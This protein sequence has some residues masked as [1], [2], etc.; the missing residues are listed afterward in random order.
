MRGPGY[1]GICSIPHENLK[2]KTALKYL[3]K[4][5][6]ISVTFLETFAKGSATTF[7]TGIVVCYPSS[8]NFLNYGL[9]TLADA[10]LLVHDGMFN[11]QVEICLMSLQGEDIAQPTLLKV[12]S[13]LLS[14]PL[15]L[16]LNPGSNRKC[17]S[18]AF[19]Y[20][21]AT[22]ESMRGISLL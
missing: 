2:K 12:S 14:D 1:I 8:D 15:Q 5:G 18:R 4:Y 11:S 16:T 7:M 20:S 9:K 19:F 22:S 13:C 21:C 3:K 17:R 10:R 6:N